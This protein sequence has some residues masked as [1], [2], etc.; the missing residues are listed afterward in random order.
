MTSRV[1]FSAAEWA[2]M[3]LPGMPGTS[4]GIQQRAQR[5]DWLRD[6]WRDVR[7]RERRGFGGGFEFHLSLLN[8]FQQAALL[9]Q[10]GAAV[11]NRPTDGLWQAYERQKAGP[12]EEAARRVRILQ[13]VRTLVEQ[14]AGRLEAIGTVLPRHGIKSRQTY[15][16]WERTVATLHP[17]DWLAALTPH[18][19]GA[20]ASADLAPDAWEM[21]KTDWLRP[22]QPSFE[23]C[24]RRV[25]SVGAEKGWTL[26]SSRTA[27]RRLLA[28]PRTMRTLARKGEEAL[29][30]MYPAQ[31]RDRTCLH[32]MEAVNSDGHKWDVFVRWP[33]G[34]IARPMM[35]GFQDLFSGK[36][37]SWRVDQTLHASLIRLAWGDLV[38]RYGIPLACLMD[39]GREYA[40]KIMTGGTPT[41]FRFKVREEDPTGIMALMG[42]EVHWSTPYSGQS[43][44]IERAWRDF[45][46]DLAKHPAFAGAY[47]GNNPLAKPENYGSKAI[48]L[49]K[50]LRVVDGA[51]TE[52]NARAGR[53][54]KVAQGRSFD[55][56]F[57]ES[58][59]RSASL[60]RRPTPEQRRLWLM[61]AEGVSVNRVDGCLKLFGNRFWAP[62]L[63]EEI[64]HKLIV[65]F[66]PEAVQQD[67]HVYRLDGAYLGAAPCVE[68]AGF[69]NKADATSHNRA[70]TQW[71]RAQRTMLEAKR[72]LDIAD[73]AA[74]LPDPEPSEPIE[75]RVVRGAFPTNGNAALKAVPAGAREPDHDMETI[76]TNIRQLWPERSSEGSD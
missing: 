1:W 10:I 11:E 41:R 52:W 25:Q 26:C 21:L 47:V 75:T 62:F 7:W 59:E 2:A 30:H 72:K 48:P 19:I 45:A 35:V 60:I 42:V 44:P 8:T 13:E 69:F 34:T 9:H 54:S 49:D 17:S 33:D 58:Y 43:K 4:R 70:R 24:W 64:G 37:L 32:A 36:M 50:F 67:L 27:R 22:E 66:D 68:A 15:Y 3:K 76:L 12:K 29:R 73:V 57:T 56:V 28:L 5:E 39:N 65:R 14:G 6:E 38:E 51:I 20:V 63:H 31:E 61:A 46:G 18:R 23:A 16:T 55:Q 40:N 74:M 53:R 71:K